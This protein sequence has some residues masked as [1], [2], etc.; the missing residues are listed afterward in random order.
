[1]RKNT[2]KTGAENY[3]EIL[4]QTLEDTYAMGLDENAE[5]V[6]QCVHALCELEAVG[7]EKIIEAEQRLRNVQKAEH[8]GEN[9]MMPLETRFDKTPSLDAVK[10]AVAWLG[11]CAEEAQGETAHV[12]QTALQYIVDFWEPVIA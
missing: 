4:L 9:G 1:M 2:M 7:A 6:M 12:I 5:A 8:L 3:M 11:S 10:E